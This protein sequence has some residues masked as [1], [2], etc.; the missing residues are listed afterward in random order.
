MAFIK[1][2]S[3]QIHSWDYDP[4]EEVL[5]TRF[6]CRP[7]GGSGRTGDDS[8]QKCRGAGHSGMYV[9]S[10]VPAAIWGQLRDAPSKGK[11]HGQLVK[12]GGFKFTF[13]PNGSEEAA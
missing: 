3:S 13:V 11:A 1:T 4:V 12:A 5:R 8:C 6:N 7:C 9:Y 2:E 10:G